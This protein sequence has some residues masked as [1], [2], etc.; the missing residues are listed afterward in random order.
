M[1]ATNIKVIMDEN[2]QEKFNHVHVKKLTV[3]SNEGATKRAALGDLQNRGLAREITTKDVAHKEL[4]DVKLTTKARVDTHWKKQPL[5]TTNGVTKAG[6]PLLRSNS[7][8][9]GAIG[10]TTAAGRLATGTSTTMANAKVAADAA[11]GK[12]AVAA[13]SKPKSIGDGEKCGNGGNTLRREDSNLSRKSLTKLRA[14]LT[15]P[16]VAPAAATVKKEVLLPRAQLKKESNAPVQL[17]KETVDLARLPK[18]RNNVP[19]STAASAKATTTVALSSRR[20]A[21]VEDIDADDREN[22]ILVSEYVNDIY[23]YLY[24]VEEQ[25]PIYPDHLEGQSEVSYKMRAILID[26]I[27][28]VHLQ[29]HL[30][31]ETF[32]LAVAIIDRYLQ[33]VK[34]TKRKNLQLVG[35]SALFIATKYE[36]LFP[37]AMC[38]FVYITDDTYTAH[39]IQKMELL[40]LKAIDNNLSRPLPIHFLR[41]YSKAASADDRHHAMSKYFLELASL[42]YNLASYK[43]SE[44]AAASLFLS[45]HLLNGNARAPTGFNDRH[46]TP[47]LV[48]YSRYSAAHLRPITRQ[49]AKLA[50][51][52]PTAKLRAIFNKY[53]SNKFHKIALSTELRGPLM[54]SIIGKK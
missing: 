15:K 5:G 54:D 6:M 30:T 49:I 16:N 29:F 38:D 41:R 18:L 31:A 48:Y 4:K 3:P 36:E 42:D 44:I 23:D 9:T 33:V 34:D 13:A 10:T 35:V 17:K 46:W 47:T 28:E 2:A 11:N 45:L 14:A 52:A 22:L 21:D 19:Q 8:R 53:Q 24:E 20:L 39:E 27:N 37:P 40:I 51:D 12:L 26:W 7:M 50:R 32:H 43:P 25:Q 1:A